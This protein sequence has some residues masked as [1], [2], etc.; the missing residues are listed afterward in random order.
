[1]GIVRSVE[2]RLSIFQIRIPSEISIL[3]SPFVVRIIPS[4]HDEK[5]DCVRAHLWRVNEVVEICIL[6]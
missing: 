3:A 5:R 2:L 4:A 1:M 6:L